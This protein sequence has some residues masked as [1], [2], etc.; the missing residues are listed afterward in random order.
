METLIVS[1]KYAGHPSVR[2]RRPM[3]FDKGVLIDMVL[4]EQNKEFVAT[5]SVERYTPRLW[6][7]H[8]LL[9]EIQVTDEHYY[10]SE[11]GVTSRI[12]SSLKSFDYRGY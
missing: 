2:M 11:H 12:V 4:D 10:Q 1:G 5:V 8:D 7:K 3:E 9:P 6:H